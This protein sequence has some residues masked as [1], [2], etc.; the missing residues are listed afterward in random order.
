[1][2]RNTFN[3]GQKFA[4]WLLLAVTDMEGVPDAFWACLGVIQVSLPT[5]VVAYLYPKTGFKELRSVS[6]ELLICSTALRFLFAELR[7]CSAEIQSC[8]VELSC[9]HAELLGTSTELQNVSAGLQGGFMEFRSV[10]AVL[11]TA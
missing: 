11:R 6:A 9:V 8:S 4:S 1:M 3:F 10:S 2:C 5:N 7:N